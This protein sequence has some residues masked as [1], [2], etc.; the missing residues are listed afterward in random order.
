ME[1]HKVIS[2]VVSL[3]L[4]PVVVVHIAAFLMV[5]L[6]YAAFEFL[7]LLSTWDNVSRTLRL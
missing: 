4:G 1:N 2:T 6:L 5:R 7:S 3:Q